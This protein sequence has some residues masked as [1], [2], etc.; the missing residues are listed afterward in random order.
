M[1]AK[2]NYHKPPEDPRTIG[3]GLKAAGRERR[4]KLSMIIN[5]TPRN[6]RNDLMPSMELQTLAIKDLVMP[7]NMVR[8]MDEGH[9]KEIANGIQAMG[10]S[11]PVLVGK[12]NVILNGASSVKA[13]ESLGMTDVPCVLLSH[14]SDDEQR[15][16]RISINRMSQKGTWDLDELKKEFEELINNDAPLANSGFQPDEIDQIIMGD[17]LDVI[18]EGDLTPHTVATA[19]AGDIWELGPHRLIC[20]SSTDP[21]TFK[22]ITAGDPPARFVLTDEPYNVKIDGNVS[23]SGHREFLMASGEMTDQEF[24]NFNEQWMAAVLPCL[25]DG[26]ILGTFI[27]WRGLVTVQV[28]ANKLGLHPL[29]LIVWAKTNAG[30]GGLYRSQ[31]ELLPLFKVG[32]AKNV[33]N[34]EL[35]KRGR[36]RSNIW[37]YPGASSFGSDAQKGLKDHPTVKPTL[38]LKDALLDLTNRGDIVI[39]PFLG[40]GSTLMAAEATG[41]VCRGVELDPIFVDVIIRRY[42]LVS[43]GVLARLISTGESFAEVVARRA[44][45]ASEQVKAA[46]IAISTEEIVLSKDG[47]PEPSIDVGPFE[48]KTDGQED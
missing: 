39:D 1:A 43:K 13:A 6:I 33:N 41:R 3:G 14:L 26:G 23:N 40:S 11:V 20:A 21:E 5:T 4:E 46:A 19:R 7:K 35:G 30:M 45:E 32:N 36:W 17:D 16:L 31:H 29:N 25:C 48:E 47:T 27:D 10:F 34:I 38:M 37:T 28:S 2:K 44:L 15:V 9:I 42:E 8:K 18:E 22:A 12:G 24:L